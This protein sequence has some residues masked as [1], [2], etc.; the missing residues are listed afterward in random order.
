MSGF[1]TPGES[2]ETVYEI[3]KSRFI[4]RAG[5]AE[6]REQAMALVQACKSTYP[7]ARHHCWAYLLGNP[8]AASSAA[9]SDDGEPSGTA[10][11]PILNVL[12]H[13]NV[14]NVVVV[15]SRYFGGIK[16]GAGGLVRAYST[17]A[18]QVMEALPLQQHRLMTIGV[19]EGDFAVEQV[20]R[21]WLDKQGGVVEGVN[22]DHQVSMTVTV[23]VEQVDAFQ[24]FALANKCQWRVLG[25]VHTS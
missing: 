11:K 5:L 13:K 16:L 24:R 21:H 20:I 17:A 4:A 10:G 22:Y 6:N 25:P 2:V 3:K 7:D 19:V 9:M 18:Q 15:V 12:Q 14:G 23:P 8:I 1:S